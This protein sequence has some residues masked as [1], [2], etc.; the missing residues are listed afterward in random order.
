MVAFKLF[1]ESRIIVSSQLKN[2]QDFFEIFNIL[3]KKTEF[4]LLEI[5]KWNNNDNLQ[6]IYNEVK[7]F[8]EKET[9]KG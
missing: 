8:I 1:I 9:E 5:P 7:N 6:S 4:I 2:Q 3:Y